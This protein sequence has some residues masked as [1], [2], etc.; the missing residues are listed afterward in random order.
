MTVNE[1]KARKMG[2]WPHMCVGAAHLVVPSY[3]AAAPNN[4]VPWA[5][6][7][8]WGYQDAFD[9]KF[10]VDSRIVAFFLMLFF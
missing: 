4:F 1:M 6:R 7:N 5:Y 2:Y 3:R 8:Y 10:I 9:E